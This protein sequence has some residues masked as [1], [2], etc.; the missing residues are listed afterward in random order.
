MSGTKRELNFG[1]REIV[2]IGTAHVSPESVAEVDDAIRT[3]RPDCA[4]VELDKQRLKSMEDSDSWRSLDVVRVLKSGQGFMLMANLVLSSFQKRMGAHVGVQPGDEM[5]AA[6]NAARELGIA[7]ELA[8]R[9]IQITLRRAWARNSLWGK[10][11]LLAAL[12][13]SA[14]DRQEVSADE[15]EN[16]KNSNEMDSMMNELA[17]YLPSVKTVLI[18]ERDRFLASRIWQCSGRRVVAV[19]G[20]G[21]LP[22]VEAHLRELASGAESPVTSDIEVIP[23]AGLGTKLAGWIFPIAIIALL[24]AGFVTGGAAVSAQMLVRWLLW[25]GSLA[26]LGALLAGG[27]ILTVI[28]GFVGAP[29]A[30]LNPLLGIGLFTGI[31]QAWIKKPKVEDMETLMDDI[32]SLRGIYHNRILRVLLVFLLSSVG[33]AAGNIIA[34]P[35]L[36]SSLV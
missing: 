24:A 30:T 18:D 15:I 20:A 9:P 28:T 5:R 31:V 16:L 33:G 11:K 36:V 17:D 8:D 14:F 10:C 4:A 6:I 2:L 22:G 1:D 35:A 34:V 21:H 12:L 25:N 32:S 19:L 3:Y 13:S 27:H 26:A 29:I 7:V 23:P